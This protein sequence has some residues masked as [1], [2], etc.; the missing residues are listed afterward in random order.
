[1]SFTPAQR[2]GVA[3]LEQVARSYES[4]LAAHPEDASLKQKLDEVR[5]Q[6]D[7]AKASNLSPVKPVTGFER[8]SP[9]DLKDRELV[10]KAIRVY[11]HLLARDPSNTVVEGTLNML[12]ERLQSMTKPAG[13]TLSRARRRR[14]DVL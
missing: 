6:L 8:V 7:Q 3:K 4:A 2:R 11:Q 9:S 14:V 10:L 12:K 1:M 13:S 5:N